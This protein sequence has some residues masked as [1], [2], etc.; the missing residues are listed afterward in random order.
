M[1]FE[2]TFFHRVQ[3]LSRSA[4]SA[5]ASAASASST[6]NQYNRG[7]EDRPQIAFRIWYYSIFHFAKILSGL[8]PF[9]LQISLRYTH[10]RAYMNCQRHGL[11][12]CCLLLWAAESPCA[13]PCPLHPANRL[14]ICVCVFLCSSF[15]F[16]CVYLF[17]G[18]CGK[19]EKPF[20]CAYFHMLVSQP[21]TGNTY[22]PCC[23]VV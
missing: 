12:I 8:P 21:V 19:Y 22:V 7:G 18:I 2:R 10:T 5:S 6:G 9:F 23:C 1:P 13:L 4:S 17:I 11:K 3:S 16:L 14:L 20:P 15:G